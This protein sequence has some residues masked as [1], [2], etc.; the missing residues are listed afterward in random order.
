MGDAGKRPQL[1]IVAIFW[2]PLHTPP[3]TE[4]KIPQVLVVLYH[5]ADMSRVR[6][7]YCRDESCFLCIQ[8]IT[9][10]KHAF[11]ENRMMLF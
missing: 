5:A 4:R 2:I 3:Q 9:Q 11:I 6:I 10:P 8:L 1:L 7:D